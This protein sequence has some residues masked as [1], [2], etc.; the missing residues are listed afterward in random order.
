MGYDDIKIRDVSRAMGQ[1]APPIG[2]LGGPPAHELYRD[3]VVYAELKLFKDA[4]ARPW[5]VL[6]DGTQRRAFAAPSAEL[7]HALDRFR[8]RRNVRPV[9]E[10]DIE[11]FVR[12][13]E[14]R[15]SDPDEETPTLGPSELER[16]VAPEPTLLLPPAVDSGPTPPQPERMTSLP[17]PGAGAPGLSPLPAMESGAPPSLELV[18]PAEPTEVP[19]LGDMNSTIS[20]GRALRPAEEAELGRYVRIL[21]KLVRD[22]DWIGSTHELSE[23][24]RDDPVT[25]YTSFLRYRFELE[26][27]DILITTVE[28]DGNYKWLAVDRARIHHTVRTRLPSRRMLPAQ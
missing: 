19:A 5:V 13:V 25:M 27:N 3:L 6:R 18:V 26:E 7:R 2:A 23:L 20:G 28:V 8:M 24:L 22:G 12:I 10:G 4:Q 9:P 1:W 15:V 17:A 16:L 11:E 21:R 14:A